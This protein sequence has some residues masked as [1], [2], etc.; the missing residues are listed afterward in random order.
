M[1]ELI[2]TLISL[3]LDKTIKFF[4]KFV[5]IILILI[6][7]LAVNNLLG[8]TS[9]YDNQRTLSEIREVSSILSDSTIDPQ[10]KKKTEY[11]RNQ[12][13]SRTRVTDF[14]DSALD[15]IFRPVSNGVNSTNN[16]KYSH[17]RNRWIEFVCIN[18]FI[19]LLLL[20]MPPYLI[21]KPV[22]LSKWK[23][24]LMILTIELLLSLL[25][26]ALFIGF[27]FIPTIY[28]Q[29]IY[30]YIFDFMIM[31]ILLLINTYRIGKNNFFANR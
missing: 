18:W 19:I 10:L 6:G 17:E 31:F 11:I 23:T 28:N 12:I 24:F 20:F 26:V 3:A 14:I 27:S 22:Y 1:G 21:I 9:H 5:L 13:I 2:K 8:F 7:L 30:N 29:P 4:P 15:D 16:K 25:A